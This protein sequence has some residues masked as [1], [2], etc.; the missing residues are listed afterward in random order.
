MPS[1]TSEKM[2]DKTKNNPVESKTAL[3]SKYGL[4]RTSVTPEFSICEQAPS[5][6]DSDYHDPIA[7][8]RY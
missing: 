6:K 7:V 5:L 1:K 3:K 2:A 8:L 4:T